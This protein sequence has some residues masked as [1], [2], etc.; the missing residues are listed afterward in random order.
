MELECEELNA[1]LE[2]RR[3]KIRESLRPWLKDSEYVRI[4]I[5][6]DARTATVLKND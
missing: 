1:V 3:K 5:D 6:T 2:I 4:E